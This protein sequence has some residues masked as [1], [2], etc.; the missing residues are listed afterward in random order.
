MNHLAKVIT[1]WTCMRACVR[2]CM[3]AC[4]CTCGHPS[5][6]LRSGVGKRYVALH[7]GG[8]LLAIVTSSC[9]YQTDSVDC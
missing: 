8:G 9:P 6:T 2:A 7:G 1:V 3:W 4:L 5:S